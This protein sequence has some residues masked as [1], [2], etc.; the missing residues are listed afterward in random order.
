[1]PTGETSTAAAQARNQQALQLLM[2]AREAGVTYATLIATLKVG[3]AGA[4]STMQR[5]RAAEQAQ[6]R[7][8]RGQRQARW[9]ATAYA[10]A[11]GTPGQALTVQTQP[12]AAPKGR[13]PARLPDDAQVIVPPHVKVQICPCGRDTRY[14]PDPRVAG[15]GA[16]TQD[17]R[18]RRLAEK[19]A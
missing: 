5:L 6:M 15:R 13:A 8:S 14:T 9:Y 2:E 11:P 10:P 12:K 18:A 19:R 4:R 7:W 3:E 16:I 1:M 17:W